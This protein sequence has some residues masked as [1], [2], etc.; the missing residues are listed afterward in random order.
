MPPNYRADV[1]FNHFE[2]TRR[3]ILIFFF[4][5]TDVM[6]GV[7]FCASTQMI[8]S[9]GLG[10]IATQQVNYNGHEIDKAYM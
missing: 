7:L 5:N 9:L 10:Y 6:K 8:V 4:I 1:K 3:F 2:L